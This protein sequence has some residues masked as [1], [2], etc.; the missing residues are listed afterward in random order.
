MSGGEWSVET[1]NT[2]EVVST[3]NVLDNLQKNIANGKLNNLQDNII[4]QGNKENI[5]KKATESM[6]KVGDMFKIDIPFL[7][8]V[9][10]LFGTKWPIDLLWTKEERSKNKVLNGILKIFGFK[11]GMEEVHQLYIQDQIKWIDKELANDSYKEYKSTEKTDLSDAQKTRTIC[12]LDKTF[13]SMKDEEKTTLQNKIPQDFEWVKN[14]LIKTLPNHI[15]KLNIST[16]NMIGEPFIGVDANNQKI[17]KIEEIQ[18]NISGFV[19]A[20]LKLTIPQLANPENDFISSTN[21]NADTFAF[22][23]FG[24]LTGEKFFVE[25]VNL[26]LEKVPVIAATSNPVAQ[27]TPQVETEVSTFDGEIKKENTNYKDIVSV[28]IGKI[29]GWYYNPKTMYTSRMGVSG[30]TMMGIDRK[31]WGTLN[32]SEAGKE[33]WKLIDE[34]KAKN[35]DAWKKHGYK[36]GSLEPRLT[37]LAW[38]IIK[39]HYEDLAKKYLSEESQKIVNSD[40]RLMFNFIYSAR[41]G[42]DWFRKIANQLN[43]KVDSGVTDTNILIKDIVDW[44]INK[45]DNSLIAQWG[46]KIE[47]IVGLAA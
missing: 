1:N 22:A 5:Q 31:H 47:E 45:S 40:G 43:S 12:G 39:P 42:P 17:I 35:P 26:G 14:T 44:R 27:N 36:W 24:N 23:L 30:E 34:D 33:F 16:V 2:T 21:I 11:N 13:A 25:A 7:G 6:K 10:A 32:T 37:E 38:N 41:N 3:T 19:D 18:K 29:E 28:V 20:Y 15:S 8:D 46:K 4:S 9:G